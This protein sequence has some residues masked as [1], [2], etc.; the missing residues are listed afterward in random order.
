MVIGDDDQDILRWQRRNTSRGGSEFSEVFF[1]RFEADFGNE[2]LQIVDLKVNFRSG[3]EIVQLSQKMI[4]TFFSRHVISRRLKNT[5]LRQRDGAAADRCERIDWRGKN[6]DETLGGVAEICARLLAENPGS[7]AV[8][9]RSN[10]EVAEVHHHLA[11]KIQRLVVQSG[12]NM[13]VAGLRHV[14]HWI[15]FIETEVLAQDRILNQS[16]KQELLGRFREKITIPETRSADVPSVDISSLWDLCCEE[17]AF[18]HLSNLLRFIR[19]LQTDELQ[20]LQGSRPGDA[21]AVV[22]TIH[23]VKGLEFDSVVIVPSRT[24]FGEDFAPANSLAKD[25]AEEARLL[26][27]AMTR[28]KTR[29]VNLVGDREYSWAA[30]PP[31]RFVGEHG[32]SQVLAGG[33][34]EV[35]LG[36]AMQV[37]QFNPD[38]DDC[39]RY[40][41]QEVCVGDPIILGGL[42]SG[43]HKGLMHCGK[44]GKLRQIG[45]I[46]KK[47][48]AGNGNAD[49]KVSAVV[50]Y[51]TNEKNPAVAGKLAGE[52]GWGYAV[53]I[54]GRLR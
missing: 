3:K 6:W 47:Y 53:L 12:A 33:L 30:S 18:P 45:F 7:L 10:S 16:L 20:R 40:I 46:A 43:A 34:D 50:R 49:L 48:G 31:R 25:A 41:E 23:K 9:C 32:Q 24:R 19:G 26:Y 28:A 37:G 17:H 52:R 11:P 35:G 51:G 44:L 1:E 29:L 15:D 8:L 36:W 21:S 22:S 5:Q 14:G 39:Q 38:P 2:K 13:S 4:S 27:V 54:A 42:G